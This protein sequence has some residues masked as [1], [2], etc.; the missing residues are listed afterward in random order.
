VSPKLRKSLFAAWFLLAFHWARDPLEALD[1]A[2][3]GIMGQGATEAVV[4][5]GAEVYKIFLPFANKAFITRIEGSYT[6]DTYF[7]GSFPDDE[8]EPIAAPLNC[9]MLTCHTLCRTRAAVNHA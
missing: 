8:W 4:A 6:G 3:R 7:P 9:H 2:S 5:G 1:F